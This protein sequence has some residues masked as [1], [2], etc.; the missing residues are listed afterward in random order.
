MVVTLG[1]AE[2]FLTTATRLHGYRMAASP[3]RP[4]FNSKNDVTSSEVD[5]FYLIGGTATAA[6]RQLS[7]RG[8][9]GGGGSDRDGTVMRLR[10]D[11]HR[12]PRRWSCHAA[13]HLGNRRDAGITIPPRESAAS[14]QRPTGPQR[15]RSANFH[16]RG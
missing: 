5:P 10:P 6:A 4:K 11:R 9:E 14:R 1:A 12:P 8:N 7:E 3:A 16:Q 2:E 13:S 15:P